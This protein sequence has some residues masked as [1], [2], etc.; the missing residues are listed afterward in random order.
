MKLIQLPAVLLLL[1]LL[2]PGAGEQLQGQTLPLRLNCGGPSIG[3]WSSDAPYARGGKLHR[4][5]R[6][7]A[8][9]KIAFAAPDEVY[10]T[11][12]R[13]IHSYHFPK[14]P[15]GNYRVRIHFT[16]EYKHNRRMAYRAENQWFLVDFNV[17]EA[18][19]GTNKAIV[20]DLDVTVRDGNGLQILCEKGEGND[21]F[22]AALEI[23]NLDHPVNIPPSTP[24]TRV[25]AMLP[26][27][28][29]GSSDGLLPEGFVVYSRGNGSDRTL[30]MARV[31]PGMTYAQ[32][33]AT[34]QVVCE[35]GDKGGDIEGQISFDGKWL[36]FARSRGGNSPAL[37]RDHYQDWEQ[38]DICIVPLDGKL[39]A[40][41]VFIDRGYFPSWADNSY[42]GRKSLYYS[43]GGDTPS[44]WRVTIDRSGRPGKPEWYASLP[45]EGYEGHAMVSPD[46]NFIAARYNGAMYALHIKGLLQGRTIRMD[47]GC[48]PHITSNSQWIYHASRK[49]NRSDG[50]TRGEGGAGGLYHFGSSAD[51]RW[52]ITR[53]GGDWRDQNSGDEVWL[54]SLL[55]DEKQFI[56]RPVMQITDQGSW[57]DVHTSTRKEKRRDLAKR[58]ALKQPPRQSDPQGR[59]F[60]WEDNISGNHLADAEGLIVRSCL[61]LP[62]GLSRFGRQHSMEIRQGS[63]YVPDDLLNHAMSIG[64]V[65]TGQF[66]AELQFVA[67]GNKASGPARMISL[68]TDASNRN[69]TLGQEG[70][71]LIFRLRTTQTDPNG[72]ASQLTLG[73]I[74]AGKPYH[75]LVTY[76][77]GQL[78]WFLNGVKQTSSEIEGELYSWNDNRLIF[79]DEWEA[80]RHW[81][82]FIRG[83]VLYDRIL[84]DEEAQERWLLAQK[85]LE[86]LMPVPSVR[87]EARLVKASV[88]PAGEEVLAQG[89]RRCVV[90]HIYEVQ[91]VVNGTLNAK[92]IK[93]RHW[94]LLDG[95]SA[96]LRKVGGLYP[97]TLEPV[98]FHPELDSEYSSDTLQEQNLPEY[99]DTGS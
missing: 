61:V 63:F 53:T 72:V 91:R 49:A 97:M 30:Y 56:T 42:S 59:L 17:V 79:G 95:V 78:V 75:L 28:A 68:S 38:W 1:W 86:L 66:A 99:Y 19:G 84:S 98:E 5:S 93:V 50:S 6:K 12:R 64:P 74:E 77:A 57:V 47:E 31:E 14:L 29:G 27:A 7:S 13:D 48:H 81:T 76:R 41:P 24:Q 71:D 55:A 80:D 92:R 37:G 45:L 54:C 23:Y 39:P 9:E 20:R 22:E 67:S 62:S 15:N 11:V 82:G 58:E 10:R 16:D 83:V 40:R 43:K 70:S 52:F 46:G 18:A 4:F 94:S 44:V 25:S 65:Y 26:E 51:M 69:F 3:A 8:T 35:K 88:V 73:K 2:I 90:T 36:A 32:I 60:I 21:V 33:R 85:G 89:Y 34:E 96:P 87:V